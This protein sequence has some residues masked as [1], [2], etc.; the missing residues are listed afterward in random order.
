[1]TSE[2]SISVSNAKKV[3]N[4]HILQEIKLYGFNKTD[5]IHVIHLIDT[6]GAFIPSERVSYSNLGCIQYYD[7]Q[8]DSSFP[9]NTIA[10]NTR[11]ASVLR[12]LCA[13][14]V[15]NKIPY[16][17]FYFSRNL[18]QV[19]HNNNKN[20]TVDEKTEY[21]DQF[22]DQFRSNPK[23]FIEFLHSPDFLVPG[24]YDDTWRFI[25]RDTNSLHRHCNLHL[26]FPRE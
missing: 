24:E 8:I 19:L 12:C 4:D 1:M 14:G 22:S 7:D 13:A 17:V 15:I 5:I 20:L 25:M 21:A 3:V 2:L 6:D 11:K 9:E 23:G 18:E 16:H 26:L 10:R